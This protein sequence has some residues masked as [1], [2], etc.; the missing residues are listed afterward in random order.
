MNRQFSMTELCTQV[1]V[2]NSCFFIIFNLKYHVT[3]HI[4]FDFGKKLSLKEDARN[5]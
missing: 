1:G 3:V 2:F 5:A 4:Q